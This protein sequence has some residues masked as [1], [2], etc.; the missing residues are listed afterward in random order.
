MN[1]N[2]TAA[3]HNLTEAN[4]LCQPSERSILVNGRFMAHRVTGV[5]RYA[6]ELT[7]ALGKKARLLTPSKHLTGIRGHAWEQFAL[8]GDRHS[9]LWSPCGSGPL[10]R[11]NQVVTIHDLSFIEHP[12]WFSAGYARFYQLIT[13]LLCRRVRHIM[14]VSEFTRTR[15]IKLLGINPEKISVVHN[16]VDARFHPLPVEEIQGARRQFNGGNPYVLFVGSIEPRK[17]LATLLQSWAIVRQAH[18]DIK[19]LVAG[20]SAK[21]YANSA[22]QSDATGVHFLGYVKDE[23]L[24]CLYGG[25]TAFVYPSLYEGF[26]LPVLEA[27]SCGAPVVTSSTTAL[28]EVT[29]DAALLVDP[30]DVK[31][32]AQGICSILSSAELRRTLREKGI[33]QASGFTW[34]RAA[35]ETLSLFERLGNAERNSPQPR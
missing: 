2:I 7:R 19:L 9:L 29:G 12:E 30:L 21:I 16:G 8:L 33:Q 20:G 3:M 24:P 22:D 32:I 35:K 23:S 25:A 34:T 13:P 15:L 10:L 28:P 11:A 31:S 27:M 6:H 14:A 18:S 17:N 4:D 26:G 5:Q 1:T